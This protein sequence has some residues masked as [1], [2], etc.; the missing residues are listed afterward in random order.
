M[1]LPCQPWRFEPVS[2]VDAHDLEINLVNSSVKHGLGLR[3]HIFRIGIS[4]E[5][6]AYYLGKDYGGVWTHPV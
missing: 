6:F 4:V 3:C 5:I 1:D 2:L